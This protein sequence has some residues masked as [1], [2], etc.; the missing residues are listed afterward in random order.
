METEIDQ[1]G[2]L[3]IAGVAPKEPG[4][5]PLSI[6]LGDSHGEVLSINFILEFIEID[7]VP[8]TILSESQYNLNQFTDFYETLELFDRDGDDLLIEVQHPT[9]VS[10]MWEDERFLVLRGGRSKV[11]WVII[12]LRSRLLTQK[13]TLRREDNYFKK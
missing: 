11:A 2:K 8:P 7:S 3:K 10:W 6:E 9:W 5:Y 1:F 13:R 12:C 4:N